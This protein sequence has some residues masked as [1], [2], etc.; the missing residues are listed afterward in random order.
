[1]RVSDFGGGGAES[2]YCSFH[3]S[4]RR[5]AGGSL[6]ALPR[7]RG[8]CC[9]VKSADAR[10]FVAGH[11]GAQEEGGGRDGF[12]EFLAEARA[13]TFTVSGMVFQDAMNLALE[14]LRRC[15]ICEADL[16]YGM[17]PFCA[18]NLTDTSGRA[19]YRR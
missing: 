3:A 19:L 11:W 7:R 16:E 17:V 18:Y 12:D 8:E 2:S 5:R 1:M 9:C 15:H 10:D 14:R 13:S 6:K 4:Y